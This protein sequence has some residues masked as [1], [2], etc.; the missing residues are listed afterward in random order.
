MVQRA[1][2]REAAGGSR[3]AAKPHGV[4]P[5]KNGASKQNNRIAG[6]TYKKLITENLPLL[7]ASLS[8]VYHIP[9]DTS[10]NRGTAMSLLFECVAALAPGVSLLIITTTLIAPVA[11]GLAEQWARI[12]WSWT[13]QYGM[14]TIAVIGAL[15]AVGGMVFTA[16]SYFDS[17][18]PEPRPPA[19]PHERPAPPRGEGTPPP[20]VLPAPAPAAQRQGAPPARPA[21]SAAASRSRAGANRAVPPR[22]A[23]AR[24]A[25][26]RGVASRLAIAPPAALPARRAAPAPAAP[27][28]ADERIQWKPGTE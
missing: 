24:T 22:A 11:R 18:A 25:S 7:L 8:R 10:A 26:A 4:P 17:R 14:N 23:S 6:K 5:A 20:A 16:L 19:P 28:A 15:A 3:S 9:R 27:R 12:L 2:T 13:V 21:P 1:V